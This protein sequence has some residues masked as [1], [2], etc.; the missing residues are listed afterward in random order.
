[1]LI[2]LALYS[3]KS[4]K[5]IQGTSATPVPAE[6]QDEMIHVIEKDTLQCHFVVDFYSI[7]GGIN[8][9]M[10]EHYT[11]FLEHQYD[12]SAYKIIRWGMEGEVKVCFDEG[13]SEF[14]DMKQIISET[15]TIIKDAGEVRYHKDIQVIVDKNLTENF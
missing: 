10:Y 1:M 15:K 11:S 7:G 2:V 5:S 9:K 13:A 4:S 12:K 14:Y 3:C 8:S 6:I